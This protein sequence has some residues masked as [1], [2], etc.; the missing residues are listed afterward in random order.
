MPRLIPPALPADRMGTAAQ[1][2]IVA[3]GL[4][5]RPWG[6][7]DA[8]ALVIA[9]ADPAIQRWHMRV[10]TEVAEAEQWIAATRAGWAGATHADW[11]VDVAG[12]VAGRVNLRNVDAF[13]GLAEIGYW[14]LP[15]AR[16]RGVATRAVTALTG[17]ALGEFGLHRLELE[18]SVANEASCGVALA[19]GYPAEGV[20]RARVRH[21]DGWHDMHVHA[22]LAE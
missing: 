14:V 13:D 11:A 16:G 10:L 5:L 22:R 2:S 15:A 3:D 18:H 17:W 21:A 19:A 6:L 4:V 8:P 12:T 1:P 9:Y 20:R 7:R